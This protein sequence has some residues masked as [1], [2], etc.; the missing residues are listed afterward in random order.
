MR[1]GRRQFDG[2]TYPL[3][4]CEYLLS[5][6][7]TYGWTFPHSLEHGPPVPTL[8]KGTDPL[9][10]F[11]GFP[12]ERHIASMALRDPHDAREMPPNTAEYVTAR[13]VRGVRRVRA[14]PT[15]PAMQPQ[16]TTTYSLR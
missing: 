15:R 7:R 1:A 10:A 4:A 12:S 14:S 16:P 8:Q 13:C 6:S 2:F 11:L 9:H 5:I 3:R